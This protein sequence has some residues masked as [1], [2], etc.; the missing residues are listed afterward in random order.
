MRLHGIGNSLYFSRK[1]G[2][3]FFNDRLGIKNGKPYPLRVFQPFLI[4]GQLP[5]QV[6]E[7][8]PQ[9][10]DN[11]SCQNSKPEWDFS[12]Q[13]I[14]TGYPKHLVILI[15]DDGVLALTE[16]GCDLPVEITDTLIGPFD[17]PIDPI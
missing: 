2:N 8:G 3:F 4:A 6:V 7:T 9:V 14:I 16:K 10:M 13:M 15:W 11:L 17:L 1:S 5:D 12:A